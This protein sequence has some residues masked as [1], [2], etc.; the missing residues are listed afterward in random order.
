MMNL[1]RGILAAVVLAVIGVGVGIIGWWAANRGDAVGMLTSGD[2]GQQSRAVAN[3]S[4]S[5]DTPAGLERIAET[6]R[7][8]DQA[9]A[10]SGLRALAATVEP[11]RPLPPPA[12]KVVE[13][14]VQDPRPAVQVAAIQ[15][16]EASTPPAPE[17]PAVPNI[18]LKAFLTEKAPETRAVAA[19]ALGKFQ[20]WDAME[21]LVEALEDESV[22]VRS[23]AG[24]AI[25]R[26]L[27]LDYG[28]RAK[29][30]PAERQAAI[31][32]IRNGWKLQLIFHLD[33]VRRIREKRSTQP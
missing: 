17:D 4:A 16:L 15:I 32:R 6:L 26:I 30:P 19:E 28:F 7:H 8:K 25:R 23:S 3:L 10:C 29:A 33:N 20:H 5:A 22:E 31:A 27:G 14:A 13:S 2:P 12:V 9:V 24:M 1:Q 11:D 21:G 18:V